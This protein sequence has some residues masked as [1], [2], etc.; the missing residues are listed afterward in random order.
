MLLGM[1]VQPARQATLQD[2]SHL[3]VPSGELIPAGTEEEVA[4]CSGDRRRWGDADRESS[5]VPPGSGGTH[6]SSLTLH[7]L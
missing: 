1:A 4:A 7:W 2:L 6:D 3:L 5:P